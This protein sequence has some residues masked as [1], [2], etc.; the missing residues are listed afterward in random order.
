MEKTYVRTGQYINVYTEDG[1]M[2]IFLTLGEPQDP[3]TAD[4]VDKATTLVEEWK[5][6]GYLE[7]DLKD[8]LEKIFPWGVEIID[9]IK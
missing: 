7:S 2:D 5:R 4:E 3:V 6:E 8:E 1:D 9:N